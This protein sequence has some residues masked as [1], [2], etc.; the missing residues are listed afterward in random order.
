MFF[1]IDFA[2]EK[3]EVKLN[4]FFFTQILIFLLFGFKDFLYIQI[5]II[6]LH[7]FLLEHYESA[8]CSTWRLLSVWR[9]KTFVLISEKFFLNFVCKY[10][11]C[12]IAKVFFFRD[13]NYSYAGC[14]MYFIYH[15]HFH[16][17]LK[18]IFLFVFILF[19]PLFLYGSL[20]SLTHPQ[21]LFPSVFLPILSSFLSWFG[22][23]LFF[24]P[25]VYQL[26]SSPSLS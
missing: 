5:S 26:T 22:S 16:T 13:S 8:F 17:M 10:L 23:F 9:F 18:S 25:D 20:L 12:P 19:W 24:I 6:C 2:L 15:Y 1:S 11:L 14:A 21:C 4:L 7:K 3:T